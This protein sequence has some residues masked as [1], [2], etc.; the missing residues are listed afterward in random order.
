[1][2]STPNRVNVFARVRPTLPREQNDLTAVSVN[3]AEASIRVDEAS[4]SPYY[5]HAD[6]TCQWDPPEGPVD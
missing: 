3:E 2:A 4:G 6:G 5:V 1:M